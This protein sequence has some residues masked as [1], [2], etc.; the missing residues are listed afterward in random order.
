MKKILFKHAPDNRFVEPVVPASKALPDWYK[1]ATVE[2]E[3]SKPWEGMTFKSCMPFFDAMTQGYI[4]PLWADL[5][6][7]V[8]NSIP[9]FTWAINGDQ[10]IDSHSPAQ[11]DGIPAMDKAVGRQAFKLISPWIIETPQGYSTLFVAPLNNA[12]EY[13]QLFSAVVSTDN[14]MNRINFPFIYTGPDDWEGVVLMGTPLMQLI[15]FKR[16]DF[17]HQILPLS[18]ADEE[19]VDSTVRHHSNQFRH[20]YKRFWRSTSKSV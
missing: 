7:R 17:E 12:H 5:H 8:E 16:D 14:Y 3:G 11:V 20:V 10:L 18:K 4:V 19:I 6:V 2:M 1:K 9:A 13:I 15:P